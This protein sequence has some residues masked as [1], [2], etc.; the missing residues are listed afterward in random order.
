MYH[1]PMDEVILEREA[2]KLSPGERALLADAILLS[3]DDD[4]T[5]E[6]ESAWA[7]EAQDRLK[8]YR[9]GQLAAL[10][11]P[12]VIRDLRSRHAK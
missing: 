1:Q 12:T 4:A 11:G 3:L 7:A 9:A 8:A 5:R 10:D 6:I 2:L